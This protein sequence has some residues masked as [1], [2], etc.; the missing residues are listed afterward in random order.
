MKK[1]FWIWILSI[2]VIS[3]VST[4]ILG[5]NIPW[6]NLDNAIFS[7]PI[8]K[9]ILYDI[10]VGI[11]S[12]MILVWCIDIIQTKAIEK[13]ESNQRQILY[14]KLSPILKKYYEFYLSLF[15]ATRNTPVPKDSPVTKSLYLCV[16]E[17]IN[18]IKASDPFY[19][20]GYYGDINKTI[21]QAKL[22]KK[23][24]SDPQTVE[25]IMKMSTSIP[26]YK[27]LEI[28]GTDFYNKVLQIERDFPTFFPNE[29]LEK[30][31]QILPLVEPQTRIS[32]IIEGKN[33]I[34]RIHDNISVPLF[35]CE[36]F[37]DAYH[38]SE[39]IKL[40]DEIMQYIE[41]DSSISLRKRDLKYFN[42]RHVTPAIGYS[43]NKQN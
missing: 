22:L 23:H 29:L 43:C 4:I 12:S 3:L 2:T 37:I 11:L 30:F 32:D 34:F 13:Q 41:N 1:H 19:K 38:I 26:W 8:A 15:I 25:K 21:N 33:I 28:E 24:S 40:L 5:S 20:D 27:C 10:S 35:P 6:D 7:W 16:D 42:E 36:F 31:E 9:S 39:I 14:N 17:L 18:Q